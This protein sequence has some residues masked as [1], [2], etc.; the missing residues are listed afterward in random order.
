MTYQ[1]R[2][3]ER[4]RRCYKNMTRPERVVGVL[5]YPNYETLDVMG[6]VELLG[7]PP[8]QDKVQLTFITQT[9]QHVKSAQNVNTVP[10]HSFNDCP[11]LDVLLV[12]G[13]QTSAS[14]C[15]S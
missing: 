15:S 12:P 10:D 6:P 11:K 8:I 3:P 7:V 5:L 9:G 1:C 2:L 14:L 4:A 13:S